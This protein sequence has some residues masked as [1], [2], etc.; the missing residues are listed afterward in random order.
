MEA[1]HNR[2]AVIFKVLPDNFAYTFIDFIR[3]F[4]K[5]FAPFVTKLIVIKIA[6]EFQRIIGNISAVKVRPVGIF[7][8]PK[9]ICVADNGLRLNGLLFIF[10]RYLSGDGPFD[11]IKNIFFNNVSGTCPQNLYCFYR[12]LF[13]S[14]FFLLCLSRNSCAFGFGLSFCWSQNHKRGQSRRQSQKNC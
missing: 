7:S 10:G 1:G 5:F 4:F 12:R 8:Q 3:V 9:R 6:L 13:F 11:V 2:L 14:F